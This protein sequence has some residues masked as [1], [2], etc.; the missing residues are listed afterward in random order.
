MKRE[1][2]FTIN[3]NFR[4]T[5]NVIV[6][7]SGSLL[8]FKSPVLD[9]SLLDTSLHL[10]DRPVPLESVRPTVRNKQ[11][12]DKGAGE[13]EEAGSPPPPQGDQLILVVSTEKSSA[14]FSLPSQKQITSY[15]VPEDV[16]TLSRVQTVSWLGDTLGDNSV[17]MCLTSDGRVKGGVLQIIF[18]L[19]HVKCFAALS[20]PTFRQLLEGPLCS[21]SSDVST[22][23]RLKKTIQFSQGGLGTF[24][25]NQNQVSI[26]SLLSSAKPQ[27]F[28]S[29]YKSFLS[30]RR[31]LRSSRNHLEN[32]IR[33]L[34][35]SFIQFII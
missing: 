34:I 9:F 10:E 26:N 30:T 29:R 1:N 27:H 6:S 32:Y 14:C 15:K 3:I 16:Y 8:R 28:I 35:R 17:L 31:K 25:T 23:D 19:L 2:K 22:L 7:P 13:R 5:E 18:L 24:F 21:S 12:S 20:L 4:E 11:S 33:L